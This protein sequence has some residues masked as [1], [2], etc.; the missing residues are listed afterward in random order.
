M[1]GGGRRG[2]GIECLVDYVDLVDSTYKLLSSFLV[3]LPGGMG[4]SQA[5]ILFSKLWLLTGSA[6]STGLTAESALSLSATSTTTMSCCTILC[7][8]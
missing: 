8:C 7:S 3:A 5:S 2:N 4:I 1:G 6:L